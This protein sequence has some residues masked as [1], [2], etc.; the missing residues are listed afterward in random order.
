MFNKTYFDQLASNI[1]KEDYLNLTIIGP[2]RT[3][4][5]QMINGMTQAEIRESLKAYSV[6]YISALEAKIVSAIVRMK[7][8]TLK[9]EWN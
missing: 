9:I 5:R 3:Q 6:N 2:A 1:E 8:D 7:F 4:A